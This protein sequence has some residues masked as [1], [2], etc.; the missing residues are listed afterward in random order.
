MTDSDFNTPPWLLGQIRKLDVTYGIGLD[1]CSN[2]HSMV[3]ARLAYSVEDD[4]LAQSWRG[5]G[6]VF[7]NPPHSTSPNNIEPWMMKAYNEF[8]TSPPGRWDPRTDQFVGLV[9]AKTDTAWF[10]DWAAAFSVRCFLKGRPR[11][12]HKGVETPGPG[13]FASMLLYQGPC[14]GRFMSIFQDYGWLA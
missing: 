4:G 11:F 6:L 10:H 9:P 7:M 3:Q 14:S 12:W 2:A 1:P 5:H 8:I 13:K